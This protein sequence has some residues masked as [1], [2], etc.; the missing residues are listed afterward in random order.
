MSEQ[1][2]HYILDLEGRVTALTGIIG[3]LIWVM[4]RNNLLDADLE[5]EI[6][7]STSRAI[8][9]DRPETEGAADRLI[10]AMQAATAEALTVRTEPS[11][12]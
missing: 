3:S 5:R 9:S 7:R 11:G 4:R 2:A 12:G 10:L 8:L 1:L 6:Y